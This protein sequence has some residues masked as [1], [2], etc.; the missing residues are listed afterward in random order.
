M[1]VLFKS[2]RLSKLN[3][4][5]YKVAADGR[6]GIIESNLS[7]GESAEGAR[8]ANGRSIFTLQSGRSFFDS[9]TGH[10]WNAFL[11]LLCCI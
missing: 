1:T 10:G 7:G 4:F 2:N 9:A 5:P 3:Y 8:R 6:E 11:N